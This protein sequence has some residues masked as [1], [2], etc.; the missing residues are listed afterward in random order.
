MK[1]F[2]LKL[3]LTFTVAILAINSSSLY[4]QTLTR[5]PYL[6][7]G[8]QTGVTI[9]WR[10]STATD[11]R[12]TF[13]TVF[14]TYTTTVDSATVTTEHIVRISGLTPDTKYY[15]TIGSTTAT[16][17]ATN[18][19]YVTTLPPANTTRK[20]RF[21]ALGDCGNASTNQIDVKNA[22]INYS[23]NQG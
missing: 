2:T 11:S 19:N 12:V 20:L 7:M 8:N 18:T 13:G 9:R 23:D 10:S 14:G 16:L 1:S 3:A 17:Q 6:Q 22:A 5:G 4:A 15:Y 21:L